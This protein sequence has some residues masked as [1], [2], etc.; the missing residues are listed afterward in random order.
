MDDVIADFQ[1]AQIGGEGVAG[2][3]LTADTGRC[4]RLEQIPLGVGGD[5][6][7][8]ELESARQRAGR[9]DDL[10]P[11]RLAIVSERN[12]EFLQ[13]PLDLFPPALG[14]GEEELAA[15]AVV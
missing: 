12:L 10:I 4:R 6:D 8:V 9:D 15:P 7:L 5:V 13:Q 2:S 1:V 14:G 3:F 11:Q